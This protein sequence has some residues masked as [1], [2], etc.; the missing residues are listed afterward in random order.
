MNSN[1][2]FNS[3]Q[4]IELHINAL[5]RLAMA[6]GIFDP[7]EIQYIQS[8][9]KSYSVFFPEFS[10][11]KCLETTLS[12]DEF[13]S[14]L[15][16]ISAS[17]VRAKLLLKDLIVLGHIDGHFTDDEKDLVAQIGQQLGISLDIV[18]QLE[19]YVK[20]MLD[21]LNKLNVVIYGT[22]SEEIGSANP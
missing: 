22:T 10:S 21:D 8:I 11:E 9:A 2:I 15:K 13:A 3:I 4:D 12:D 19:V 14:A 16:N 20:D 5:Y 7:R 17:P 18:K 1:L 6:D